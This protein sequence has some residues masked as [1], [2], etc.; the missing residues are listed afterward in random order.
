VPDAGPFVPPGVPP[1]ADPQ[2]MIVP[3]NPD[4]SSVPGQ[5]NTDSGY[6][7]MRQAAQEA[8]DQGRLA[9]A[10]LILSR[11]YGAPTLSPA[12]KHELLNLLSQLAGSV[13]YSTQHLIEPP[14]EVQTGETLETIAEK[15]NVPWQ[16]LAKI[17]GVEQPDQIVP[18]QQLK[19]MRGP[20]NAIVDLDERALTLMVNGYYAGRFAVAVGTEREGLEGQWVVGHKATNPTYYGRDRTID[21]DDPSNPL[22]EYWIGLAS[23]EQLSTDGPLGIH[24]TYDAQSIVQDDPR[25]Y[26]RMAP[27]DAHDVYDILSVGSRVIIRR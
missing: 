21:A 4:L 25:G 14:H 1:G 8:L 9:E 5:P 22:G 23:A 7:A 19:V 10:H 3:P 16:L 6:S 12:E 24:G 17:N 18:G 15:Y 2:K 11:W 26:I 27:Q 13:I 20:F